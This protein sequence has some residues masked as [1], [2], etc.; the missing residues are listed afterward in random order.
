MAPPRETRIFD[1]ALGFAPIE[2]VFVATDSTLARRGNRWWMYLA[3]KLLGREGIDL[4]AASLPVGEPL[5]AIGWTLLPDATQPTRVA[6]LAGDERS[7]PWDR[8]GGRH[9]PSYVEGWDPRSSRR[10]E[11]IYYAGGATNVWGPYT[12]GYLEWDGGRW[13]DQPEPAFVAEEP[14]EHG[15]VYEPNL[16]HAD[17]MWKMWYVAGSNREDYL[18]Q[19]YAESADGRSGWSGRRVFFPPEERV[20]DFAVTRRPGG[21]EAVFSRVW[22]GSAAPPAETGLWWC[23]AAT[24]SADPA[25][26]SRPVQILG[27]EDR[28]WHAGPWKPCLRYGER[29]PEGMFVFFDGQYVV[30]GRAGFPYVFTL[31]C[32]ELDRPSA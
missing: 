23:C 14:W 2:D 7:S 19:G 4:F 17:G 11:R 20:F 22:L 26:W 16:V 10:V 28:G 5:S 29:G 25:G 12:I 27:A 30:P 1:P 18:V 8:K 13:V 21:Y 9:C 24:P 3:G 6:L 15:S 31:G 32:L